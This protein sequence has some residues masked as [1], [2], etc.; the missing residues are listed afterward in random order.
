MN[1]KA[2]PLE[3]MH[4]AREHNIGVRLQFNTLVKLTL[5]YQRNSIAVVEY[6]MSRY[7]ND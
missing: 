3:S 6:D 2:T 5:S 1:V 7:V 4:E